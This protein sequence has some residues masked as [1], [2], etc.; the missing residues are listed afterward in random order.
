VI[1]RPSPI[2]HPPSRSLHHSDTV[3]QIRREFELLGLDRTTQPVLQLPEH[4]LTFHRLRHGR[5]IRPTDVT[6][7]AM[8]ATQQLANPSLEVR[9]APRAAPATRRAEICHGRVTETATN[10]VRRCAPARS[11]LLMD[12]MEELTERM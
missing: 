9:V 12:E 3:A 11:H 5:A 1:S 2:A 10:A 8:H 4:R 6:V 7:A